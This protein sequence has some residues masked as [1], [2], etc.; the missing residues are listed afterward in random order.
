MTVNKNNTRRQ[1]LMLG[2]SGMAGLAAI[3][4]EQTLAQ[5]NKPTRQGQTNQNQNETKNKSEGVILV[6]MKCV[7]KN[8]DEF[9]KHLSKNLPVTRKREGCRYVDTYTSADKP[10]EV[11]LIEAWDSR[12]LHEKYIEWRTETGGLAAFAAFLAEPPTVDFWVFNE[13]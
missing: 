12:A 1:M 7:A 6:T 5:T 9:V 2:L 10:N 8:R 4:A 13:A 11:I 3:T